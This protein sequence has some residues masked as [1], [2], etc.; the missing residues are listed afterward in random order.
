[1]A[2]T[3]GDLRGKAIIFAEGKDLEAALAVNDRLFAHRAARIPAGEM[4]SL[5]PLLPSTAAQKA[6]W[7]RWAAYW[8]NGQAAR[9]SATLDREGA[10]LGFSRDAFTPFLR[11]LSDPP[12]PV[13][14]DELR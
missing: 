7:G 3:W 9:L 2:K 14:S 10:R 6:N 8:Q 13:G 5:A 1:M 11:T 4:V 12:Q